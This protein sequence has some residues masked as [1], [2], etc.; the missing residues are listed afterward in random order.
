[1][2]YVINTELTWERYNVLKKNLG[3]LK[4]EKKVGIAGLIFTA[5]STA[6]TSTSIINYLN[7]TALQ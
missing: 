7:S 1:M 5:N 4:K 3:I 6:T 2:A